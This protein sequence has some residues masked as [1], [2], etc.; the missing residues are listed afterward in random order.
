MEVLDGNLGELG[1]KLGHVSL[2]VDET[3]SGQL[4]LGDAKV[5]QDANEKQEKGAGE[6]K[7]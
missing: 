5:L 2:N 4:A 7:G 3:N 1:S 6:E